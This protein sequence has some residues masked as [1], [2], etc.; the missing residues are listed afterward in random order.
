M[1][2]KNSV[3]P[4]REVDAAE[5]RLAGESV[6]RS[7][8]Q[9]QLRLCRPEDLESLG[10]LLLELGGPFYEER[11]PRHTSAQFCRWKY[12]GN[13]AGEAVVGIAL[14]GTRVVSAVAGTPKYVQLNSSVVL[15]FELGDFITAK[16]YRKRGFFSKL[17]NLVCDTAQSHGAA[18]VY[19]RPNEVSFPILTSRLSFTECMKMD[20]RRYV[21]PS[22]AVKRK[23]GIPP[24]L[25]RTLGVDRA[26]RQIGLGHMPHSVRVQRIER[27]DHSADA[28]W[29]RVGCKYTFSLAR[30]S[31]YLNWRY[32][33]SPT[34]YLVWTATRGDEM[35]GYLVA[36]VSRG[37]SAATV[38]DLFA[39][40]DDSDAPA[41][42]LNVAFEALS[43]EGATVFYAWTPQQGGQAASSLAL[44]RMCMLVAKQPL[45]VAMRFLTEPTSRSKPDL[46]RVGWQLAM[47]DFDGC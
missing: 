13:P 8:D 41:A 19:V 33:D 20:S 15:A 46:P 32:I 40:P 17:I 23:F 18:F 39:G 25:V 16:P 28:L 30:N 10:E 2:T 11:F 12:Y 3:G 38:V 21:V 22:E 36:F 5:D 31:E 35:A 42:L 14:D 45:H 7:E 1:E 43:G 26:L 37:Q 9:C 44:R 29:E 34:P 6:G 4:D 24:Q 47:G 27:F